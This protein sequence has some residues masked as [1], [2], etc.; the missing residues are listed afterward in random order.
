MK[1]FKRH[2]RHSA[3]C[4]YSHGTELVCDTPIANFQ[5]ISYSTRPGAPEYST[6]LPLYEGYSLQ[7]SL[8][9]AR[10]L[11]N[12]LTELLEE[13]D[14]QE[15]NVEMACVAASINLNSFGLRG[16]T[17]VGRS[18]IAY[19]VAASDT[20]GVP[21]FATGKTYLFKGPRDGSRI[22]FG[23]SGCEIPRRLVDAPP[24]VVAEAFKK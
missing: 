3:R 14:R 22:D 23:A 17:F 19:E 5:R 8:E 21:R 20:A 16:Y 6:S 7:V 13:F 11:R 10:R 2:K 4:N 18:G 1:L 9:E 12:R 15:V 24:A